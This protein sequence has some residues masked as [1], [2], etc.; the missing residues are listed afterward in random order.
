MIILGPSLA[1][2]ER[3]NSVW[4]FQILIKCKKNYWQKFYDWLDKN[5]SISEFENKKNNINIKIDV[6]PISI[7]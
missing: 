6:D 4:R 2:I 5:I 7:L 1:P 3:I